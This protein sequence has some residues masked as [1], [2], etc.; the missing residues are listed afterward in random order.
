MREYIAVEFEFKLVCATKVRCL[1]HAQRRCVGQLSE[2]T[3]IANYLVEG[4]RYLCVL[5]LYPTIK[6]YIKSPFQNQNDYGQFYH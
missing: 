3:M 5:Q 2:L 1:N 4:N 6:S